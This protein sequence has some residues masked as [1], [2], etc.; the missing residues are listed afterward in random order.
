MGPDHST[1]DRF[2]LWV[3]AHQPRTF[4]DT[5]LAQIDAQFP[6]ERAQ[7]QVGDTFALQADAAKEGLVPRLRHTCR[8]LLGSLRARIPTL[9]PEIAAQLAE[10]ALCG[11]P[12][13]KD[14][15]WLT[16]AERLARV[17]TTVLAAQ[18]CAAWVRTQLATA[19]TLTPEAQHPVEQW[20]AHL[21]KLIRDE[22]TVTAPTADHPIQVTPLPEIERGHY[23]LGSATDPDATYRVHGEHKTDLGY[24]VQV[25]VTENFVR[26][27]EVSTGAQP[28]NVG[29]PDLLTTQQEH[30]GFLPPKL[31]YDT[32]AGEGKTRARV[33]EATQS[34]TQLVAPLAVKDKNN[35]LFKPEQFT[36]AADGKALTCPNGKT[37]EVA[38]GSGSGDGRTFRFLGYQCADC[39][40][41]EKCRQDTRRSTRMRQVF[42]SDYR[43]EVEAARAY[44]QTAQFKADMQQRPRVERI[45]AA[46]VR[47]NG[48]RR[49]HR[50]GQAK[51]DFQMKLCATAYNLKKWMQVLRDRESRAKQKPPGDA[52]RAVSGARG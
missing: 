10:P 22:V 18:A 31:I 7:P 26:A 33:A 36:L 9:Q 20:L 15:H 35:P 12:D 1:L 34:Q 37:T 25:A 42:I 29:I 24:N 32:A 17:Q 51:A 2:E 11:A 13:E 52:A 16:P 27:I 50:R 41:W 48:A 6:G 5:V 19:P 3:C 49:A 4:F 43:K 44:N 14:E 28:D 23:R 46:L 21:D 40:L 47:Y 45:I 30:Q 38:Y 39:P 8:H